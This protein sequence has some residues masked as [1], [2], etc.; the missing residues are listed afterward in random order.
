MLCWPLDSNDSTRWHHDIMTFPWLVF[1][2][3][4]P[5]LVVGDMYFSMV[6][7]ISSMIFRVFFP[8][9]HV[10]NAVIDWSGQSSRKKR[11]SVHLHSQM[12]CCHC[13]GETP[14]VFFWAGPQSQWSM[15]NRLF[16][17]EHSNWPRCKSLG[18]PKTAF[19][20]Q[21]SVRLLTTQS[22]SKFSCQVLIQNKLY[23]A[24]YIH[25]WLYIYIFHNSYTI[26][27]THKACYVSSQVAK[28]PSAW[29]VICGVLQ[30]EDAM[31]STEDSRA[32]A[33]VTTWARPKPGRGDISSGGLDEPVEFIGMSLK[34]FECVIFVGTCVGR[35]GG[36]QRNYL[37]PKRFGN[38]SRTAERKEHFQEEVQALQCVSV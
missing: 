20:T 14:Y 18:F 8:R 13:L 27:H 12:S 24:M 1:E 31:F 33:D 16:G 22:V 4:K 32:A 19:F 34:E 5:W 10:W 2:E 30:A 21:F 9:P 23:I 6:W 11:F 26:L 3:E 28:N 25:T 36:T 15:Q 7:P 29:W 35:F 37:G 38:R 17:C